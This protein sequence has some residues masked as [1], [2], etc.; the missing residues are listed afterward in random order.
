MPSEMPSS[1][2]FSVRLDSSVLDRLRAIAA[3]QERTVN[4]IVN[5]ALT[6]YVAKRKQQARE[7]A[8]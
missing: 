6:E 8:K 7:A 5:K 4:W 3:A 1:Q 2:P